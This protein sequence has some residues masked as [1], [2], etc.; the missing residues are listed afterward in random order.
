MS[1]WQLY[2]SLL[3]ALSRA[4][5]LPLLGKVLGGWHTTTPVCSEAADARR[6]GRQNEVVLP[7][8][9]FLLGQVSESLLAG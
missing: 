5:S 8:A 2:S 7:M 1:L 4:G 9:P 3:P 6:E